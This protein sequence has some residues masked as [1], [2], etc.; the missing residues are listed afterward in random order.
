MHTDFHGFLSV[1][2]REI[3]VPFT[4]EVDMSIRIKKRG[5]GGCCGVLAT[6]GF[7][8]V[9]IL[10]MVS[11]FA[12]GIKF[13]DEY[14]CAIAVAQ[15]HEL[16]IE[17]LGQPLEPGFIAWM[18]GYESGGG[19]MQTAFSTSLSGPRGSGQ[20]RAHVYRTPLGESFL[21]EYNNQQ[22]E[23]VRLHSGSNPCR[24]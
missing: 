3:R 13:T 21:I 8:L 23:W 4:K 10:G 20:V 2:I 22:G 1:F 7:I 24:S 11:I 19:E 17:E 12:F 18:Q 15:R 9:C 16:V 14:A 5:G 6:L